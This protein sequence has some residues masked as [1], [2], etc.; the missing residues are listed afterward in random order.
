[1]GSYGIDTSHEW[2]GSWLQALATDLKGTAINQQLKEQ[3]LH[4]IP[5]PI[6]AIAHH[7]VDPKHSNEA[8]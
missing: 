5:Y 3:T 4:A 1:M 6:A 8:Y 2:I 7:G